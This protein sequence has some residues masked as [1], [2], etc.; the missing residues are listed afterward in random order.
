[1]T[2]RSST[3]GY[4]GTPLARKLGI[5]EGRRVVLIGAPK[6]LRQTDRLVCVT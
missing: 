2:K 5:E 6:E 1:M 3:A 4:P